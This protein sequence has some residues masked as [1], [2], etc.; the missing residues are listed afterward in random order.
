MNPLSDGLRFDRFDPVKFQGLKERM[1][2]NFKLIIRG[3]L[4]G[5]ALQGEPGKNNKPEKAFPA[6]RGRKTDQFIG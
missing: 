6:A 5:D 3:F 2:R 4:C 1:E